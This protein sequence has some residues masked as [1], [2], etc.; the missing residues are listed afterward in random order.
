MAKKI[1]THINPDLDALTSVWL[2]KRF[3]LEFADADVD[4]VP[5]GQTYQGQLVDSDPNI[6][7]VDTGLGQFDHHQTSSPT[8]CSASQV[9]KYLRPK[10]KN[11]N[12]DQAL[13]RLI[14]VVCQID[15]FEECYWP[16][17]DNDRYLFIIE[18]IFYGLKF[19]NS[20]S[21]VEFLDFGLKALD[22]VYQAF[23]MRVGAEEKIDQ[24]QVFQTE[25][26]QALAVETENDMTMRLAQKRG[27]ILVVRKNPKSGR[28]RIKAQPRSKIDLTQVYQQFIKRDPEA[29]WYLHVSKSMLLNGSSKNP[30]NVASKLGLTE[31]IEIIKESKLTK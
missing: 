14:K 27:Y 6:I 15:H 5:A 4:Y 24:G 26:G 2:L 19:K 12:V 31:V 1:V 16:E 10:L 7:H 29:T 13:S 23:L 18:E 22:G 25:P 30:N 28:I 9:L 11:Q 20:L 3:D 17:P 21:E 8:I